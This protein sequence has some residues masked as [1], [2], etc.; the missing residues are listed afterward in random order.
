MDHVPRKP[1]I[2]RPRALVGR[3]ALDDRAQGIAARAKSGR[4]GL[5]GSL[6][7]HA[8]LIAAACSITLIDSGGKGSETD[9]ESPE[10]A[11]FMLS[12]GPIATSSKDS[13][14]APPPAVP[15]VAVAA[16]VNC[17]SL[18]LPPVEPWILQPA[19]KETGLEPAAD[20]K[21]AAGSADH[22]AKTS[23]RKGSGKGQLGKRVIPVP[24]PKL[25][26]APP[27]RYPAAAKAARISG[28][29][30]VLIQVRANGTAASTRVYHGSGNPQ[31]DLAAV[32]G[33]RSWTFSRT[34]SLGSGATVAVVVT[35]TFAP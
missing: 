22:T 1:C 31:L 19:N 35:V 16:F 5:W 30:A 13:T 14:T 2:Q 26:L 3:E 32:E 12:S 15:R 11:D 7:I 21:P 24:P 18:A 28:K 20:V 17:S 23:G 25:L 4:I 33:A 9:V 34:P 8:C 27:P 10:G 6:G 29:V